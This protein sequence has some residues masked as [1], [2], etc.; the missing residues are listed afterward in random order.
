MAGIGRFKLSDA[1]GK[2]AGASGSAKGKAKE[3]NAGTA[4][5]P[6]ASARGRAGDDG[7]GQP[8]AG[9]RKVGGGRGA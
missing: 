2:N 1:L 8:A 7:R 9:H 3:K 4:S 6:E 5:H